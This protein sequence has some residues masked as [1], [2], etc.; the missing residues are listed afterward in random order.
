MITNNEKKAFGFLIL[1]SLSNYVLF[2]AL[3]FIIGATTKEYTNDVIWIL[4]FG[5]IAGNILS[6]YYMKYIFIIQNINGILSIIATTLF[7]FGIFPI[8]GYSEYGTI[9]SICLFLFLFPTG[10]LFGMQIPY[11]CSKIA[12]KKF[13]I[14]I[15]LV[16][17]LGSLM[18]LSS[19]YLFQYIELYSIGIIPV[20]F[21]CIQIYVIWKSLRL[22]N[23][24]K[25]DFHMKKTN[26]SYCVSLLNRC[27]DFIMSTIDVSCDLYYSVVNNVVFVSIIISS[28]VF[29]FGIHSFFMAQTIKFDS[30]VLSPSGYTSIGF[31]IGII[32]S[33]SGG[34]FAEYCIKKKFKNIRIT[35]ILLICLIV[36]VFWVW[37]GYEMRFISSVN[38]MDVIISTFILISPRLWA[39]FSFVFV[40]MI[41][42]LQ[43][44]SDIPLSKDIAFFNLMG[45]LS[46]MITLFVSQ[47]FFNA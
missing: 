43:K 31:I 5:G 15:V 36:H 47:T 38:P 34:K 45:G 20:F 40:V 35:I 23:D 29:S 12:T 25:I 14:I 7:F 26:K 33:L 10:T 30:F 41:Y 28:A 18:V 19:E 8:S 9:F 21:G 39:S 1:S 22:W 11:Y 2:A 46:N 32:G 4:I 37:A 24:I 44:K 3:P 42:S 13:H 16:D 17:L 27:V 6:C